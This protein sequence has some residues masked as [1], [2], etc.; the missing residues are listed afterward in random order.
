MSH[1]RKLE[2][3]LVSPYSALSRYNHDALFSFDFQPSILKSD[4]KSLKLRSVRSILSGCE[5]VDDTPYTNKALDSLEV[6]AATASTEP[7]R[8]EVC[9]E[10]I[11][12]QALCIDEIQGDAS[13]LGI[14]RTDATNR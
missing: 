9:L 11:S 10:V 14:R 3:R 12:C 6:I 7:K 8:L 2:L 5:K 1:D 13:G 4:A